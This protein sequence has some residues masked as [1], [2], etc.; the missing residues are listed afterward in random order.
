MNRQSA[1]RC[2]RTLSV[3]AHV[4]FFGA[5]A[6]ILG[7]YLKQ[8]LH[9]ALPLRV[10]RAR[11]VAFDNVCYA[12]TGHWGNFSDAAAICHTLRAELPTA[13]HVH[14]SVVTI[15]LGERDF[16]VNAQY[17]GG[18]WASLEGVALP[19]PTPGTARRGDRG[20]SAIGS[21]GAATYGVLLREQ[22]FHVKHVLCATPFYN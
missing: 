7:M 1:S 11:W 16:W 18:R 13:A 9:A 20:G 4:I 8:R 17:H 15:A 14:V 22:C 2:K 6:T 10:C 5:F 21:C 12:A 3:T 19:A